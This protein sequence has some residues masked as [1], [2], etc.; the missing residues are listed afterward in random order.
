[1]AAVV[2]VGVGQQHAVDLL[3]RDGQGLVLIDILALLHTAVD[4]NVQPPCLQ[5]GAAACHLMVCA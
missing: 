3:H 4:Q 5:Q 1:M 2:D